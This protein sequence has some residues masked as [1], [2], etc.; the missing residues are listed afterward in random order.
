MTSSTS[1]T[2]T[3]AG[4]TVTY[5]GVG[6]CTLVA[7]VAAGANYGAADGS[8]CAVAIGQAV[9]S[10]PTISNLPA[11]GTYGNSFVAVVSTTGDGT[12]SVTSSTSSTCTVAGSTVTYAGTGSCRLVAHLAA[13]INYPAADGSPQG[14]SIG[15]A[16]PSMP[17]IAN[18]PASGT[19]GDGFVAAVSTTGD[20][21]TSV[22]S[23]TPSTC[24][25]VG[26]AINYVGVG[27]CRL[28]ARVAAGSN[29]TAGT[30]STQS[31]TVDQ[32][33]TTVAASV[34][35]P[36]SVGQDV[37]YS[38]TVSS[39]AGTPTGTVDFSTQGLALCT[40]ILSSGRGSCT[41]SNTPV[42]IGQT[43]TAIYGGSTDFFNSVGTAII[44]V[45]DQSNSEAFALVLSS[46]GQS[47]PNV[48]VSSGTA[49]T[50]QA[51]LSG[52]AA[53]TATGNITYMVFSDAA[54]TVSVDS[55]RPLSING[56]VMPPSDA[57]A[58]TTPDSYY[59][60]AR[61][62]G[63]DQ[64]PGA[65]SLCGAA[66]EDVVAPD[67][68]N[69]RAVVQVAMSP[70]EA[71]DHVVISSAQLSAACLSLA[72]ESLQSGT[73]DSPSTLADSIQVVLDADGNATT[74]VAGIGCRPGRYDASAVVNPLAGS[75]IGVVTTTQSLVVSPPQIGF[76]YLLQSLPPEQV[77][78]GNTAASG[79][80]YV[81]TVFR[82]Q[83]AATLAGATASISSPHLTASCAQGWRWESGAGAAINAP[84]ATGTV[85]S[86]GGATFAFLGAGCTA[87]RS[88][89]VVRITY[90]R[91]HRQYSSK[92]ITIAP[93]VTYSG[94]QNGISMN[95]SP[96]PVVLNDG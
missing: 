73:V 10:S 84:A 82:L 63:D 86:D 47:G 94:P 1:T 5:V 62:S 74:I 93:A 88:K 9:A 43:V 76:P 49:T 39:S 13:G 3:V 67:V 85:D 28:T 95:I 69:L 60:Q 92:F 83:G 36:A 45:Y 65:T 31:I 91:R 32:A 19:Y 27:T 37:T 21:T 33:T 17:T 42:G 40:A 4:S 25:V 80:S 20:G 52:G 79:H 70:L 77:E 66:V 44:S 7:H 54:C 26:S 30:G 59:W 34:T 53:A 81:Y 78:T 68:P 16:A 96:N 29:Y 8:P 23:S 38:A 22:T 15:R 50:A 41:A 18:V 6:P 89:V 2:C 24:T 90:G 12:T 35:S 51:V 14:F 57:I 46:A 64:N 61:Y 58:L 75:S 72:F 55:G 87:G 11:S 71:G 56:G 48:L